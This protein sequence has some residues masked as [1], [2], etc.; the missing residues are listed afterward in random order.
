MQPGWYPDPA[1][2]D[3]VRWWD[4]GQWTGHAQT[5]AQHLPQ[6]FAQP[7][8]QQQAPVIINAPKQYKTSHGFHL[9]MSIITVGLWLPVWLIVG[10][11]NAA[12]S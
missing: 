9:I 6:Q 1:R 7:V 8:Y 11:M 2:P 4:G 12:R 10:I 3:L 5:A